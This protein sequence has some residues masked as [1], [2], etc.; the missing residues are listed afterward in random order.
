MDCGED[1]FIGVEGSL[2]KGADGSACAMR[3]DGCGGGR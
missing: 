2:R 1:G 3:G